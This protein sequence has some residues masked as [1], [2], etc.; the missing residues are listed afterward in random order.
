MK[1]FITGG[2]G[3]IGSHFVKMAL[4]DNF[5]KF[6]EILVYDALTYAG[7]KSNLDEVI[8]HKKLK[9]YEGDIN[10]YKYVVKLIKGTDLVIN[11][12]A[13]SH[14][15]RSIQ[16]SSEF[17]NT[18][19]LGVHNILKAV[20]DSGVNKFIQISTDEVY[21][22]I[23]EGK[24]TENSPLMPNS[25]YSASKASADLIVRSYIKTHGLDAIITRSSNNY[26][27]FQD[28]E[29]L[30]PRSI[31]KLYKN[32]KIP[33]FGNGSNIRNWI[34][35]EDN[36]RA[37]FKII[38]S[39]KSGEIYNIGGDTEISNIDLV[40]RISILMGKGEDTVEFVKD[41]QGH[42]FRYALDDSKLK[43]DTNFNCSIEF[44]S[45]IEKTIEWYTNNPKYI[46]I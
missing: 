31:S 19:I 36:C 14:V 34:H 37:I 7:K 42:D 28:N 32:E 22:S 20:L 29:K 46:N 5:E 18:N 10:D 25:P 27:P 30:I 17:I 1:L 4:K 41:R 9:F 11:F 26:G 6:E 40:R 38:E 2:A 21:G 3:F 43:T 44:V 45:G 8:E 15:D 13:E 23:K 12:A 35:V 39:G 16:S 33:V 24:A